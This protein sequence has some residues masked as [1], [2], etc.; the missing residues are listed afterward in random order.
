[1]ALQPDAAINVTLT[2]AQW[3]SVLTQM[4]EGQRAVAVLMQFIAQQCESHDQTQVTRLHPVG[5]EQP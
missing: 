2:A 4:A 3:N 1:M 5:G